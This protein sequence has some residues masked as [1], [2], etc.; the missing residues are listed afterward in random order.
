MASRQSWRQIVTPIALALIVAGAGAALSVY[1]TRKTYSPLAASVKETGSKQESLPSNLEGL[2]PVT[3][4]K[5]LA[6]S[7]HDSAVKDVALENRSG[8]L[9]YVTTLND[10]TVRTFDATTGTTVTMK[11]S[12]KTPAPENN[13]TLPANFT[14]NTSFE[15][16]RKL[17]QDAFPNGTISKIHLSSENSTVTLRVE[18][19][20]TSYVD[21]DATTSKV[22]RVTTPTGAVAEVP[23]GS[24]AA[25]PKTAPSPQNPSDTTPSRPSESTTDTHTDHTGTSK[26]TTDKATF[27]LEG[28]LLVANNIY[29]ITSD[30]ITYTIE[31]DQDMSS[32]VGQAVRVQGKL[33]TAT[34]IQASKVEPVKH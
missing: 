19:A 12:D 11:G 34:T 1:Q 26:D 20:D 4:V 28:T 16:A 6:S 32:L 25:T 18:F 9:V 29:T 27:H 33:K 5:E 21:I 8:T 23:A 7:T 24:P 2:L 31:S 3:D 22:V 13:E 30:N 14:M 17:A 15:D 10:G